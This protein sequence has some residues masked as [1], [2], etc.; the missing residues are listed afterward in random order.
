M[1]KFTKKTIQIAL[2]LCTTAI[3][4]QV[5]LRIVTKTEING[6]TIY[7]M[8]GP[9]DKSSLYYV[10]DEKKPFTGKFVELDRNSKIVRESTYIS[11]LQEGQ[12]LEWENRQDLHYIKK[13][14][15]Y[16]K[17]K[18][19]GE[20]VEYWRENIKKKLFN[21]DINGE[22]NGKLTYYS[23]SNIE[24]IECIQYYIHGKRDG[25]WNW[26]YEDGKI[27]TEQNFKNNLENGKKIE[28]Y[29]N[30]QKQEESTFIN[31]KKQG[32]YSMWFKNGQLQ[33]TCQ[34]NLD[35]K[36]GKEIY[37]YENGII[38]KEGNYING[39]KKGKF[40]WYK[41]DGTIEE[42]STF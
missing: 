17:G 25:T 26:F 34:F 3:S 20:Y 36:N 38:Q 16:K 10:D 42:E 18:L 32:L 23:S 9:N 4:A 7:K 24:T 19:N 30:Q 33:Y 22:F 40:I 13:K 27:R 12:E 29:P 31:D 35:K 2:V 1:R 11:G 21:Y 28:Y 5:S 6:H 14:G 8:K 37:Y 15:F 39:N 41:I